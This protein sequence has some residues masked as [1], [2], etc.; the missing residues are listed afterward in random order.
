MLLHFL[1]DWLLLM[2][3]LNIWLL[4]WINWIR[5]F[6]LIEGLDWVRLWFG[7]L[8]GP[9]WRQDSQRCHV[10]CLVT[11]KWITRPINGRNWCLKKLGFELIGY[12]SELISCLLPM[13]I[14]FGVQLIVDGKLKRGAVEQ[15]PVS[16]CCGSCHRPGPAGNDHLHRST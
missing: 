9:C 8:Y 3:G 6:V 1:M 10:S 2:D 12:E 4:N 14:D 7:R 15:D 11:G 5:W 16:G 13:L